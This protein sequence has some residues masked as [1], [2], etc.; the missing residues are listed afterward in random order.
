MS[1]SEGEDEGGPLAPP[2]EDED[3]SSTAPP[4]TF[5]SLGLDPNLCEACRQMGY[6][7]PTPIQVGESAPHVLEP[8][9]L[10][11]GRDSCF[12]HISA[13]PMRPTSPRS[14]SLSLSLPHLQVEAIPWALQGR[15]IIG[16]AETGSG[17]TAAFGLP[18]LHQLLQRPQ[19]L[20][21]LVIS[22]TRELA[23]QI[24]GKKLTKK[25]LGT[26]WILH[27]SL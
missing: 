21:G 10:P 3:D 5:E 6:K 25:A 13:P 17:K 12:C 26:F 9:C 16:L 4:P 15:D 27:L 11:H 22:P 18:V 19:P 23:L 24:S 7:A 20:F 8:T 1:S 2:D 14:L